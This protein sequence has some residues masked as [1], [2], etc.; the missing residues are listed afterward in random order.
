MSK[1]SAEELQQFKGFNRRRRSMY[2]EESFSTGMQYITSPINTGAMKNLINV[3][4]ALEDEALTPREG[5]RAF[6]ITQSPIY[7][8]EPFITDRLLNKEILKA[9]EITEEDGKIYKQI[10]LADVNDL[11]LPMKNNKIACATN[12]ITGLDAGES[13]TNIL[14]M[15]DES[16]KTSLQYKSPLFNI[17]CKKPDITEVHDIPLKDTN[18]LTEII[19]SEMSVDNS[20]RFYCFAHCLTD[21]MQDNKLHPA[22]DHL[23]FTKFDPI[24]KQYTLNKL[25]P[26]E[27]TSND[28]INGMYNMLLKDPY[29]FENLNQA[30][31]LTLMGLYPVDRKTN[32]AVPLYY[33]YK[34]NIYKLKVQYN[35]AVGEGASKYMIRWSWS[36]GASSDFSI[37]KETILDMSTYSEP[38]EISLDWTSNTTSC[39]FKIEAFK[40]ETYQKY[41]I[42]TQA[43]EEVTGFNT[44]ACSVLPVMLTFADR[45]ADQAKILE[46][47][48]YDL[49]TSVGMCTWKQRLVLWGPEKASQAAFISE[50]NNPAWFPY[51]SGLCAFPDK[52]IKCVPYQEDL[53]VFTT[54]EIYRVR[55][56]SDGS[57]WTQ[58]VLQKNLNITESDGCFIKSIRNM[59]FYKSNN[60]F[61]MV[62]PSSNTSTGVTVAPITTNIEYLIDHFSESLESSLHDLYGKPLTVF[63]NIEYEGEKDYIELVYFQNYIDFKRVYNVY[64]FKD[65]DNK[66]INYYLIYDTTSRAWTSYIIESQSLI[67]PF[68]LDITG[69]NVY[70]SYVPV[71]LKNNSNELFISHSVQFLHRDSNVK[72][73]Y[74]YPY[75]TPEQYGLERYKLENLCYAQSSYPN[76]QLI[77]T[78]ARE[79]ESDFKKRFREVQIKINNLRQKPFKL[80]TTFSIDGFLR[81][82]DLKYE[83]VEFLNPYEEHYGEIQYQRVYAEDEGHNVIG[84]TE[85]GALD[86]P[87]QSDEEYIEPQAWSLNK[88]P[89]PDVHYW[90]VRIPVSGKGYTPRMKIIVKD[91]VPYEILNISWVWRMLF[92][93]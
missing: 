8:C 93:R 69:F 29:S 28:A 44:I 7:E 87:H 37:V 16:L 53:L 76:H 66:Y 49:T 30:S 40:W 90:K 19:G 42:E 75:Q 71:V 46:Y 23:M 25:D 74:V 50:P 56:N 17:H 63:K 89:F 60:Y 81:Q 73:F 34:N 24:T 43:L 33:T 3:D 26:Y 38:P 45:L 58:T 92:A 86:Y 80:Y 54:S 51:P 65:L 47:M 5:I 68:R 82:D 48:N 32:K 31:N 72:D 21:F 27:S 15:A 55:L 12:I 88:S 57:T 84:T 10:F 59:V 85:L 70:A 35:S 67:K 91:Q 1:Y 20:T 2:T 78:G 83:M 18:L 52:V 62:V 36:T 61:Y 22:G 4:L 39:I 14:S 6:E 77:D 13:R 11:V 79:Q 64:T 9:S 41:N